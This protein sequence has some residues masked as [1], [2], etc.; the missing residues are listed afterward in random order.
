[1]AP[2]IVVKMKDESQPQPKP[3]GKGMPTFKRN[4]KRVRTFGKYIRTVLK[5]IHPDTRL[6]RR[7]LSVMNSISNDIA[8]RV[9]K[10]A[11]M[12]ALSTKKKTISSRE[13]QA[14]VRMVFSGE[15]AKHAVSEG[16]KAVTKFV[17][18]RPTGKKPKNE[19]KAKKA[20]PVTLAVKSGLQFSP[21]MVRNQFKKLT[22]LRVGAGAPIYLAA[23]IEYT[24][25]EIL[26]LAGNAA[27]DNKKQT[28]R[29]RYIMMAIRSDEELNKLFK[30]EHIS[31]GGVLPNIE[32]ALLP[33][34]NERT[35]KPERPKKKRK[36]PKKSGGQ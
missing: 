5:Q 11:H 21:S 13:V 17:S 32:K 9:I 33:K 1:M 14:A 25:A 36:S 6:S 23:V 29:N 24:N 22:N 34:I 28:V 35:G 20:N 26:E 12:M 27:R 8:E 31:E 30:N 18:S 7:S 10:E 19:P 16:T 3:Q 15:L 4:K 2:K